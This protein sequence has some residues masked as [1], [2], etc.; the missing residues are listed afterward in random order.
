MTKMNN[1]EV[2]EKAQEL[3][4]CTTSYQLAKQL[5]LLRERYDELEVLLYKVIDDQEEGFDYV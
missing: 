4:D 3:A 5:I 2:H 1:F